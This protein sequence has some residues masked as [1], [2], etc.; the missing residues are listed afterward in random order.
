[1]MSFAT[2]PVSFWG[3]AL[4]TACYILNRVS[5]KSGTKTP[6]EIWTGRAPRLSHLRVWGCP[7]YVKRLMTNKL[8]A[9]SDRCNF[10]G[11]PKESKGYI[12]YQPDEQKLFVSLR[13]TFLEKEFLGEGTVASNV[14][15]G[16]IQ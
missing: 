11:Y 5:S 6:Y 8:G 7:A 2:L 9:R 3:L 1:M 4:E 15:F 13:A 14:E 16:E 12:F 10:V